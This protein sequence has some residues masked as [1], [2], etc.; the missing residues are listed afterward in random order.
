[1]KQCSHAGC[2]N[3]IPFNERYCTKH[4]LQGSKEKY[5]R[6]MYDS[7]ESKYQRFYKSNAWRK[8]SHRVLQNNP[9]CRSCYEQG[10]IR[11]ADVVDH[12]VEVKDNWARRLDESNLQPLC[13]AC[14]NRKTRIAK[15]KRQCKINKAAT[16]DK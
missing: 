3:L 12:I 15:E 2:R 13:Y 10:I 14:H 8:L 7:D 4:K 11:K 6:R 16:S 5:R 1:M 9:V